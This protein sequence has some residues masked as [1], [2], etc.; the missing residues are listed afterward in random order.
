MGEGGNGADV[1]DRQIRLWGI[2]AQRR[3]G[4]SCVALVGD[5]G[6]LLMHELGKNIVL[7]GIGS[8]LVVQTHVDPAACRGFLEG[9]SSQQLSQSLSQLNPLIHVEARELDELF[10]SNLVPQVVCVVGGLFGDTFLELAAKCRSNHVMFYAGRC[11]GLLGALAMDLGKE[12]KYFLAPKKSDDDNEVNLAEKSVE[13]VVSTVEFHQLEFM[14]WNLA[15]KRSACG[16]F[17][18]QV[19][20]RFEKKFGYL[21]SIKQRPEDARLFETLIDEMHEELQLKKSQIP[22]EMLTLALET[23]CFSVAAVVPVLAGFYGRE[24]VNII[25]RNAKPIVPFFFFD[26]KTS[27]GIIDSW[28]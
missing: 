13:S 17:V 4:T 19:L 6:S 1:Y 14:K 23:A 15:S 27:M 7:A 24:V 26:A 2:E 3:L 8:V 28:S 22:R 9:E 25:A 16:L 21:P 5:V 18:F 11:Y 12:F 20:E 10:R